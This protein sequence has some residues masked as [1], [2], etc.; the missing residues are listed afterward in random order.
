MKRSSGLCVICL[1][2]ILRLYS[3]CKVTS[4]RCFAPLTSAQTGGRGVDHVVD[5][6]GAGTLVKSL[7]AARV[8]GF[9]HAVGF[10]AQGVCEPGYFLFRDIADHDVRRNK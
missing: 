5:I 8:G 9:V 10:V 2:F 6:G 1:L 3:N 7:Q 4:T